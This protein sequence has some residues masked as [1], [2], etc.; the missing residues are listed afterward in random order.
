ML[1]SVKY[2]SCGKFVSRGEWIHPD[3]VIDS[4]EAILVIKG[5]VFINENGHEYH[6]TESEL[7]ILEPEVRHFGYKTS[8]NTSFYWMHWSCD[9]KLFPE[10]KRLS[11]ENPYSLS[12]LFN[13]LLN[14]S[15]E[16]APREMM[17][18]AVRL[19]LGE[20]YLI[21]RSGDENRT[22][23]G[24]SEWIRGNVDRHMKASDVSGQFGYN[25]DYISRL[26]KK[27]YKKS[28]KEFIDEVKT[29]HIKNMLLNTSLSLNEVA[30]S[31]G[32]EEY[33]YFLKFF[34]Y[35]TGMTPTAFLN[36]YSGT[37]VNNR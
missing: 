15:F 14:Y 9:K 32:F 31:C 27:T 1:E 18:Y 16:N 11:F 20:I 21:N 3:R 17:D 37:H 23:N 8:T 24:I 28:L 22:V 35:H 34:K 6:L 33:K 25:T 12:I 5:E 13:Q 7:L 10:V 30:L 19:I 26:F 2:V 4:H 29:E 36:V